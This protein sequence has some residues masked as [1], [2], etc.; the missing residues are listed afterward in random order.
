MAKL[1]I[2]IDR[3]KCEGNG[4]CVEGCPNAVLGLEEDKAV[5]IDAERC[6]ECYYCESICPNDAIHVYRVDE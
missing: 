6:G 4:D 1:R 5:I 3:D 2:E